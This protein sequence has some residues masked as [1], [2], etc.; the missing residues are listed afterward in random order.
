[1]GFGRGPAPSAPPPPTPDPV[2]PS[3]QGQPQIGPFPV[4]PEVYAAA[5]KD[6]L[7]LLDSISRAIQADRDTRLEQ[8]IREVTTHQCTTHDFVRALAELAG[9]GAAG[10]AGVAGAPE[11]GGVSLYAGIAAAVISG[12]LG[13]DDLAQCLP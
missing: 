5:D 1:M 3:W 7:A 8:L 13:L 10:V 11:T 2:Q 9:A 4:P 12:G 6:R